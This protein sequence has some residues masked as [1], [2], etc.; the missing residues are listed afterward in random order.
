SAGRHQAR[1]RLLLPG[2]LPP[3]SFFRFLIRRISGRALPDSTGTVRISRLAGFGIGTCTIHVQSGEKPN[4]RKENGATFCRIA[5]RPAPP[6]PGA[7][8]LER[9]RK[10]PVVIRPFFAPSVGVDR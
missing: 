4:A 5:R 10:R 3:F 2:W 7:E 1:L 6:L 9:L 8:H